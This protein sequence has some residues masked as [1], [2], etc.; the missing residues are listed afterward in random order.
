M[1][2]KYIRIQRA[3]LGVTDAEIRQFA[4]LSNF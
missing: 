1:R 4:K 3:I 2:D